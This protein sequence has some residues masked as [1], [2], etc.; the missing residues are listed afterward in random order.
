[1]LERNPG[2]DG[3]LYFAV[4]S[5]GIYC[6]PSCPSRRPRPERVSFFFTTAEAEKA[7][8]RACRRCHPERMEPAPNVLMARE[9]CRY[10]EAN[11][12]GTVNLRVLSAALGQSQF[13]LQRTF[14]QVTG[15]SPH[16]YLESR[17]MS[18][19]RA[20]LRFGMPVADAIYEAGFTSS[21]RVYERSHEHL[22]MTPAAYRSGAAQMQIVY[23]ITESPLGHLLVAA[24]ARGICRIALDSSE[25][26]LQALLFG[27]FPKASF[28]RD[29]GAL[30]K[31]VRQVLDYLKG[32]HGLSLELP[33]DIRATAFQIGVWKELQKIPLGE[34]LTYAEVARRMQ[35]PRAVRAVANAC[36][37]NPI[38]LA[39]PCH[40]VVRKG[41]EL[42]GYRWGADRKRSLLKLE[43]EMAAKAKGK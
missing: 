9:V 6:K 30:G 21:S 41:G 15:V 27:E 16:E 2:F 7:G 4:K 17:R 5:T 35:R 37:A 8:Y 31:A 18:Q 23:A 11:F 29:E 20:G 43:A 32:R 36:A 34:T 24:T 22:G 25:D 28:R 10:I 19:F 42:G 14:K 33:L 39:V 12:D 1:M 26:K 38:A 40:R 13:H 3:V